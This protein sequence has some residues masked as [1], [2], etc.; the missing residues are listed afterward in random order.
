MTALFSLQKLWRP[1][2]VLQYV[3][4]Q[5]ELSAQNHTHWR[6]LSG[7]NGRKTSSEEGKK[8][9]YCWKI[10]FFFFLTFF[11]FRV[12]PG[13]LGSFQSELPPLAYATATATPGPSHV[14]DLHH[15]SQQC[16][17]LNPL[18]EM[19]SWILV[20]FLTH[21]ATTGTPGRSILMKR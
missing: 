2:K 15:S 17:I 18:T 11:L 21:W 5:K 20:G 13:T 4:V 19:S 14:C 8:R 1:E 7:M 12:I 9:I 6:C 3:S 10:F 16:W